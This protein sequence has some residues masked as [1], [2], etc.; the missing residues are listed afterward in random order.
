MAAITSVALGVAAAGYSIYEGQEKK[1]KAN[2][3]L[4]N[5]ERQALDNA[6][7]DIQI[8]TIGSDILREESSRNSANIVE[9]VQGSGA[10]GIGATLPKLQMETNAVNRQIQKDLDDQV[11]KREYAI[12]GD[13]TRIRDIREDRDNQNI[14]A[15]SSQVQAGEDMKWNGIMGGMS[16]LASMGRTIGAGDSVSS[17]SVTTNTEQQVPNTYNP[18]NRFSLPRVND[19]FTE[20]QMYGNNYNL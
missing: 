17:N 18:F 11:T 6:F 2:T 1:K 15:L 4:N 7:E 5:Y 14:N 13:E 12:A 20:K 8:S 10:R 9:A 3:E 19:L 16:G